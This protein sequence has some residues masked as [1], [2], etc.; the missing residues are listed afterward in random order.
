MLKVGIIGLGVISGIH[1]RAI[2]ESGLAEIRAVCDINPDLRDQSPTEAKFYE[3]YKEMLDKEDLDI[4]H[5]CLP[6]YLHPIVAKDAMAHGV[7]VFTEKPV[8]SH[9]K[10]AVEMCGYEKTYGKK[11]GVC[12]QNRYNPS[13][14]FLQEAIGQGLYGKL[15]GIEAHVF[16]DRPADYYANAPWRGKEKE[17]GSGVI[18]NQAV[19]TLDFMTLLTP[20][21][22]SKVSATLRTLSDYP[23]EVED[24]VQAY[25][26]YPDGMHG[27]FSA[28]VLNH[29]NAPIEISLC[30]E[31]GT[32]ILRGTDV[33]LFDGQNYEKIFSENMLYGAKFYYGNGHKE[34]IR[35]FYQAVI[36]NT[37]L[38]IHASDALPAMKLYEAMRLS[39]LFDKPVLL[40]V[41]A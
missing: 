32:L 40:E 3:D 9:Y 39:S 8:S 5:L 27:F 25:F 14:H 23:I 10:T 12:L 41:L 30:F 22:P 7:H 13:L 6:H 38:Y 16:W 31:K 24:S 11:L 18:L 15:Q 37:N 2:R 17:A 21:L 19:H 36:N 26:T 33:F 20:M 1:I 34:A 4:V 28:T 35:T 29:S